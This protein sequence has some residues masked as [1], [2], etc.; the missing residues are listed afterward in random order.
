MRQ[1]TSIFVLACAGSIAGPAWSSVI[2]FEEYGEVGTSGPTITNEYLASDGAIFSSSDGHASRVV[3]HAGRN[4][5]CTGATSTDCNG[6]TLL[7]WSNPVSFFSFLAVG[8]ELAGAT[9]RL[10]VYF[11]DVLSASLDLLTDG[12]PATAD[13]FGVSLPAIV[14]GAGGFTRIRLYGIT[15]PNGLGWD[16][17]QFARA[18]VPE[19][20]L[21]LLLGVGLALLGWAR[22]QR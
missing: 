15:D 17:F 4:Y 13:E 19:P 3:S 11:N 1:L 20:R 6:E 5:L 21:P 12:D 18:G 9:A 8:D 16:E 22:R 10:D 14:P 7:I 2:G